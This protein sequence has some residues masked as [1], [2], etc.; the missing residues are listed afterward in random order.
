MTTTFPP[1]VSPLDFT[2]DSMVDESIPDSTPMK[3]FYRNKT[4]FLT[5]G[6]G[7]LGQLYVEKLLR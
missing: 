5:G 2:S 6:T 4:V 1:V 7:F 3:D